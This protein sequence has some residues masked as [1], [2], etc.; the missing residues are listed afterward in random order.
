MAFDGFVI[1]N[2]VYELNLSLIHIYLL[3]NT[4]DKKERAYLLNHYLDSFKGTVYRQTM[5]AEFEMKSNQMAE[6]GESLNAENLC[7]LYYELNQK[8]FGEDMVSDPQDVYKRQVRPGRTS[9]RELIAA[10]TCLMLSICLLYT[11]SHIKRDRCKRR[12]RLFLWYFF[13]FLGMSATGGLLACHLLF[14]CL[15]HFLDHITADRTILSGG[16]ISVV[17]VL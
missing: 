3:A 4:T 17:A 12:S 13:L 7:K 9:R 5:F 14:L 16:K 15:N 2:L 1:S 8:Y 6:E 10:D 11:S